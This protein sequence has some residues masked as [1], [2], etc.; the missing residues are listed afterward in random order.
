MA[1]N[2]LHW[3]PYFTAFLCYTLCRLPP[4]YD[5]SFHDAERV[6]KMLYRPLG[7]TGLDVSILS[8]GRYFVSCSS[9]FL[10]LNIN[11]SRSVYI[12][13]LSID[14]DHF[15]LHI[16]FMSS[17]QAPSSLGVEYQAHLDL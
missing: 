15:L 13:D 12:I 2:V 4:T 17:V 11:V 3:I 14:I 10:V 7:S 6:Q 1:C 8:F 9:P 16:I 5:A